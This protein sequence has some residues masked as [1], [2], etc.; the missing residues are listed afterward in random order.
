MKVALSGR[1]LE[2][3]IHCGTRWVMDKCNAETCAS[4]W[5]QTMKQRAVWEKGWKLP[6]LSGFLGNISVIVCSVL[7]QAVMWESEDCESKLIC[8]VQLSW[9]RLT[10][11]VYPEGGTSQCETIGKRFP[12]VESILWE[13][14][15]F[16]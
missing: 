11:I 1:G 10:S 7:T 12:V 13:I 8:T 4:V 2:S 9:K 14:L 16:Q 15:Q 6:S 5:T 3:L